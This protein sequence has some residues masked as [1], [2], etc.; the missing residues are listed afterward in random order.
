MSPLRA[1][2]LR[3]LRPATMRVGQVAVIALSALFQASAAS[4]AGTAASGAC[5]QV[6]DAQARGAQYVPPSLALECL[7]SVPLDVERN[8]ALIA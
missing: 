5:K 3:S 6:A 2:L 4:T 7:N 1:T 8:L